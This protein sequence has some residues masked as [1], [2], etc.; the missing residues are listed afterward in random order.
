MFKGIRIIETGLYKK[1][2]IRFDS[3]SDK[4]KQVIKLIPK[5]AVYMVILIYLSGFVK[6][7]SDYI[8]FSIIA[9]F[10]GAMVFFTKNI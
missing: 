5:V 7:V 2:K 9:I 10:L 1:F 4:N 3:L 6:V 8:W